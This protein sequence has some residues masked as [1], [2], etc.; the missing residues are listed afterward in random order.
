MS[1][2]LLIHNENVTDMKPFDENKKLQAYTDDLDEKISQL[3]QDIENID[4]DIIYIKDNLSSNYLELYGFRVAYHIRLSEGKNKYTPIVILSDIDSHTLNK[5]DPMARI[6]FTKNIF[7][8][9]NTRE[10]I[11]EFTLP[12]NFSELT[13]E[14]YKDKFLNLIT[15]DAPENSTSHS[16]ANEWA[17]ERW[18][19]LLGIENNDIIKTNRDKMSSM[20]YFKYLKQKYI[21]GVDEIDIIKN[22]N[23]KGKLLFID[24]KGIN[25]WNTIVETYLKKHSRIEFKALEIIYDNID[26]IKEFIQESVKSF[27]PNIILLDLRLLKN[28]TDDISGIEILKYIKTIDPSIQVI[29][30]TASSDSLV[31]DTLFSEG[32]FGYVKKDAPSEK[33]HNNGFEKLGKLIEEASDRIYLKDIYKIQKEIVSSSIIY[34]NELDIEEKLKIIEKSKFKK[35]LKLSE[36]EEQINALTLVIETVFNVLNSN[37]PNNLIFAMQSIYKCIETICT[38][39][40]E[41]KNISETKQSDYKSFWRNNG[42]MIGNTSTPN[43]LSK[44]KERFSI[45]YEDSIFNNLKSQRNDSIHPSEI[46]NRIDI[47]STNLI[48]WFNLIKTIVSKL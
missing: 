27:D 48:K 34:K 39:Y 36:K 9:K 12:K 2:K 37:M 15:V 7:I 40:I 33:S 23:I 47:E 38:Y 25:G 14:N 11:E 18:A 17:I 28:E 1:K 42:V 46:L 22:E 32:I 6:L 20:L 19:N 26:S 5:L 43:K 44:I 10:A 35:K 41:E 21:L 30:F 45:E 24:D 13:K 16:I 4:Y 3:M 29:M 31:L 8:I